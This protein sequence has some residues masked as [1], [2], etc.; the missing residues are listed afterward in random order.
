MMYCGRNPVLKAFLNDNSVK[1]DLELG[2]TARRPLCISTLMGKRSWQMVA[3]GLM[4]TPLKSQLCVVV[5]RFASC[6][7]IV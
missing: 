5:Q 7:L 2:A 6:V 4:F 3:D 1:L